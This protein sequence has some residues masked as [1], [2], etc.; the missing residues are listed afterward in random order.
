MA[1]VQLYRSE[2]LTGNAVCVWL[3]SRPSRPA[4]HYQT[5]VHYAS[6][7]IR[8]SHV[9]PRSSEQ[10]GHQSGRERSTVAYG[11]PHQ[12]PPYDRQLSH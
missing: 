2:P 3:S 9:Q 1:R 11:L 7:D 12:F 4:H 6:W 10:T 5:I 8:W